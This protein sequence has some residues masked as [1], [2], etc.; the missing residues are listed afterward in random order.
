VP[1]GGPG[2]PI[3]GL[4]FEDGADAAYKGFVSSGGRGGVPIEVLFFQQGVRPNTVPIGGPVVPIGPNTVPIGAPWF[5][6]IQ[7]SF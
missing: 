6:T 7:G 1:I 3:E 2:V 5:W 4:F